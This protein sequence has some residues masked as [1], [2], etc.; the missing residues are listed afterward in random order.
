MGSNIPIYPI[1]IFSFG[2]Q[3]NILE[4]IFPDK[5]KQNHG[6]NK[7]KWEHRILKKSITIPESEAKEREFEIE[8]RLTKYPDITDENI[9]E[10]FEDLT[11]K[12]NIKDDYDENRCD[13]SDNK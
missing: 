10:L 12:M 11:N 3:D 7:Y 6:E 5:I 13:V 9:D 1:N 8:W 4:T 2:N